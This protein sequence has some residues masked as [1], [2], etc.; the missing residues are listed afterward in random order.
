[1][2]VFVRQRAPQLLRFVQTLAHLA[3]GLP[4]A[5]IAVTARTPAATAEVILRVTP[6]LLLALPAGLLTTLLLPTLLLTALLTTA[7]LLS[8]SL[9]LT[10]LLTALLPLLSLLTLLALL[11]LLSSLPLLILL[12]A[13]LLLTLLLSL[14]LS[15]LIVLLIG[16]LTL[17]PTL[18]IALL[19]SLLIASLLT[20]L[21]LTLLLPL[22]VALL[23]SLLP[24]LLSLT[25]PLLIARLLLPLL[26]PLLLTLLL[27]LLVLLIAVLPLATAAQRLQVVSEFAGAVQGVFH[28]LPLFAVGVLFGGLQIL[29][30]FIEIALNNLLALLRLLV[31]T[32]GNQLVILAY[33]V[34]DAVAANRIRCL[35]QL[36]RRLLL[37]LPHAARRLLDVLL[38]PLD[39]IGE[40]LLALL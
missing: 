36:V 26:L 5:G 3:G 13:S 8:L 24:L 2:Q 12:P 22:L 9:L 37:V 29:H 4:V 25:L 16:L 35:A 15:L 11:P 30:N 31:M 18:L 23:I 28:A 19:L 32:A 1:M 6:S 34:G 10:L 21:L 40:R 33:A 39:L 14:L 7:L 38:Q 20:G 17:L 27:T